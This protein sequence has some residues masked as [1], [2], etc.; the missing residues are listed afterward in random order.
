M[1][2]LSEKRQK[3]KGGRP[4]KYKRRY[5]NV[6][7]RLM[8]KGYSK[9]VVAGELRISRETLYSWGR[10]NAEFLDSIER[11]ETASQLYWEEIGM[12]AVM[13]KIKGFKSSAWIYIMKSRF[14][15]RDYN[16]LDLCYE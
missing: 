5:C 13:G 2:E 12:L 8:S 10:K 1:K 6:V 15:W 9:R 16:N 3:N 7:V 11:G 14:G 4:T